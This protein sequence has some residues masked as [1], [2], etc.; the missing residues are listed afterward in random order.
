[1]GGDTAAKIEIGFDDQ[2]AVAH[3]APESESGDGTADW[4]PARGVPDLSLPRR[5]KLDAILFVIC[6]FQCK[7]IS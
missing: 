3:D 7:T 5:L 1:V 4:V 6:N 2:Y